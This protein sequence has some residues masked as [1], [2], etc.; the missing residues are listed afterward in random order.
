MFLGSQ[1]APFFWPPWMADMPEM[2]EHFPAG[3]SQPESRKTKPAA[4]EIATVRR[5]CRN[6]F[7]RVHRCPA[8][9]KTKPG[10]FEQVACTP[11]IFRRARQFPASR[12]TKE[13]FCLP[14]PTDVIPAKAGIHLD[15]NAFEKCKWIPAFAGMTSSANPLRA[16][17]APTASPKRSPPTVSARR[18]AR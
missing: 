3:A 1:P 16:I 5:K 17:H 13:F 10:A 4:I 18:D 6:I 11:E 7:R 9:R 8:S 15:L 2:Q 14:A 12:K